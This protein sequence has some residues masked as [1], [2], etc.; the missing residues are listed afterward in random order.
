M[1]LQE[2]PFFFLIEDPAVF[3][4]PGAY[5]KGSILVWT[6]NGRQNVTPEI[7]MDMMEKF[8]PDIYVSLC[9]GSTDEYSPQKRLVKA[10]D[11]SSKLFKNCLQRHLK[12]SKLH[13]S[14]LLGAIEGGYDF[15]LRKKSISGL[16]AE[17]LLGYMIDG[18][19]TNSNEVQHKNIDAVGP[20]I[21]HCLVISNN[22]KKMKRH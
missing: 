13:K 17:H 7:Y 9:D 2:Y 14:G 11:K 22:A 8:S 1:K 3:S 15:D 21:E 6:K 16:D 19:H 10:V 5:K 4:D 12:S 20:I 18:L